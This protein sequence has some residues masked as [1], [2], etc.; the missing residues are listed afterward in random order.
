MRINYMERRPREEDADGFPARYGL[1]VET[2]TVE[3]IPTFIELRDRFGRC[4]GKVYRDIAGETIHCGYVFAQ[5]ERW[6]DRSIGWD[7]PAQFYTCETW[8]TFEQVEVRPIN[9]ATREAVAA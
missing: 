6:H 8:V 4:E 1:H 2:E 9:L 3:T 5:R 7:D